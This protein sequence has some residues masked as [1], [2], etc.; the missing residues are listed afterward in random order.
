MEAF[1]DINAHSLSLQAGFEEEQHTVYPV[2]LGCLVY[3]E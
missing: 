1:T 2:E 3:Q